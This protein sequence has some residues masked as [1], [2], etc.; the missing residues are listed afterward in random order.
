MATVA[1][2]GGLRGSSLP[3]LTD[4][5]GMKDFVSRLEQE[6]KDHEDGINFMTLRKLR[7][8]VSYP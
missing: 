3:S 2:K 7:D 6:R 8:M 4:S 5:G 1:A